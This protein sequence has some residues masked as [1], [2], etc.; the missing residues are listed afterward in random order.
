VRQTIIHFIIAID[1]VV[2]VSMS[3]WLGCATGCQEFSSAVFNGDVLVK[4]KSGI[5]SSNLRKT[6]SLITGYSDVQGPGL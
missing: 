2:N 3:V 1:I 5:P 6:K 4:G